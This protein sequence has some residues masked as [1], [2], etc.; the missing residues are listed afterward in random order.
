MLE[1]PPRLGG[2]GGAEAR[3]RPL[4]PGQAARTPAQAAL[5]ARG[6]QRPPAGCSAAG[7]LD[8]SSVRVT[9]PGSHGDLKG[10][11]KRPLGSP[12]K[13]SILIL[14]GEALPIFFSTGFG[15]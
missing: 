2:N 9:E 13:E 4:S 12:L 3:V 1:R 10:Y 8:S 11:A 6:A 5:P 7:S 15:E 14:S